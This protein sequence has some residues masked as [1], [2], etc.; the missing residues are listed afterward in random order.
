MQNRILRVAFVLLSCNLLLSFL[1]GRVSAAAAEAIPV[2]S[3]QERVNAILGIP[4]FS[5]A[6]LWEEPAEELAARLK[7]PKLSETA[8]C[9]LFQRF[10]NNDMKVCG[11]EAV[12]AALYARDAKPAYLYLVFANK[13]DL[14]E[15]RATSKSGNV[16]AIIT[17]DYKEIGK[18]ISAGLGAP[19]N[20][21]F[22]TPYV[23]TS[24]VWG[25]K[26]ANTVITLA[27][28]YGL[29]VELRIMPE[30]LARSGNITEGEPVSLADLAARVKKRENGD[31][32]ITDIL[33]IDQGPKGYCVPATNE[34][35]LRYFG[36]NT[37]YYTLA[38][39]M[40]TAWGGG[41]TFA[42]A[43]EILEDF[44]K[45]GGLKIER[46]NGRLTIAKLK[47]FIDNGSPLAWPM[48]TGTGLNMVCKKR[49]EERENMGK[50]GEWKKHLIKAV[51]ASKAMI[52]SESGGHLCLLIGYNQLT[53]EIAFSD[54]WGP[55]Y[56]IRW[57][58][59]S[60]AISLCL[61]A[62]PL[63]FIPKKAAMATQK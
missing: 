10:P 27:C 56:E 12:Y 44:A 58:T 4:L 18:T 5:S 54:S 47:K 63:T 3:P 2:G 28:P 30:E 13:G 53:G 38:L 14:S 29:T 46:M 19:F 9:T 16:T 31:V 41:T 36:F 48:N 62:P 59:E 55:E 52:R 39:K 35:L 20:V 1:S 8:Y 6:P 37:E 49:M 7:L 61:N 43:T 26:S 32:V 40:R 57:I 60:E 34:R 17:E 25:W 11:R 15:N 42:G 50:P 23:F 33:M 51:N 24:Q 22:N 21:K 45:F